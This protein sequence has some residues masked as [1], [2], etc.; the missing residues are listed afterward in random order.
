MGFS[1][2]CREAP[3]KHG[4]KTLIFLRGVLLCVPSAF[5]TSIP[6]NDHPTT[7]LGPTVRGDFNGLLTDTSGY[8]FM[9]EAGGRNLRVGAS[10]GVGWMD[11]QRFKLSGEY[12]W[13]EIEYAFFSN[14]QHSWV[15][16]GALGA[17]YEYDLNPTL[18]FKPQL[19]LGAY[20]ADSGSK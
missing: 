3:M 16:Q 12:L 10:V 11:N 6:N 8:S 4:W 19:N 13:Q 18:R 9:G 15:D 20:Y 5:A 7:F 14:N 17:R 2:I 1:F